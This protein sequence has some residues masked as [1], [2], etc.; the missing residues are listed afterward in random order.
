[1]TDISITV[2][3]AALPSAPGLFS[4]WLSSMRLTNVQSRWVVRGLSRPATQEH[5]QILPSPCSHMWGKPCGWR[6]EG[7]GA[8]GFSCR[9]IFLLM[10][11]R[12]EASCDCAA[13]KAASRKGLEFV[14]L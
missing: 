4:C 5:G 1:M 14:S 6:R 13:A 10:L 12:S 11:P 8:A 3:W 2:C 9:F 7:V